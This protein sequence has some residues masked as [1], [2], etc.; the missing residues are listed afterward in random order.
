MDHETILLVKP[1][2]FIYKIP[3]AG[4]AGRHR[5]NHKCIQNF[6]FHYSFST[7]KKAIAKWNRGQKSFYRNYFF[8]FLHLFRTRRAANWNLTEPLWTGRMRLTA[9]GKDVNLRLEDKNT[10]NLYANCPVEAYPGAFKI[11]RYLPN[12][13]YSTFITCWTFLRFL[14]LLWLKPFLSLLISSFVHLICRQLFRCCHWICQRQLKIFRHSR[15]RWQRYVYILFEIH[16]TN[17]IICFQLLMTCF[18]F[19]CLVSMRTG[20]QAHL[21]LGFGDRSDSFDLNVA[22]QDH[23]KWVKNQEKIE[24][25]S[26]EPKK[27]MNLGF[28]EGET[29]KI[30]MKITVSDPTTFVKCGR[31]SVGDKRNILE[32][33]KFFLSLFWLEK[34]WKWI[35]ASNESHK[36]TRSIST[37]TWWH[38]NSTATSGTIGIK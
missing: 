1:E 9:K 31:F 33:N 19:D 26:K 7:K 6:F 15:R 13:L 3:P 32:S 10:G 30:N 5:W 18:A 22:L 27:E 2:V 12:H 38:K 35:V 21:G 14:L 11:T 20:R 17:T 37:T 29:I 16:S 4:K 34:R 24:Q 36:C 28:R 25:E 23:Y 8:T